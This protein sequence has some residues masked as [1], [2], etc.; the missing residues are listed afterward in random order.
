M[1]M[2]A[3]LLIAVHSAIIRCM[4]IMYRCNGLVAQ[5]G[6]A[7]GFYAYSTE[8]AET[9][10]DREFKSRRARHTLTEHG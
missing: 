2:Q 5:L 1:T 3:I 9:P 4:H 6:S 8:W 7:A 10:E